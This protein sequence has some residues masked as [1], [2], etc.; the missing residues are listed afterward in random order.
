MPRGNESATDSIS[1]LAAWLERNGGKPFASKPAQPKPKCD[2]GP[3]IFA[4]FG[5]CRC[6]ECEPEARS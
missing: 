1:G 3:A 5:P 2:G 4:E 6:A